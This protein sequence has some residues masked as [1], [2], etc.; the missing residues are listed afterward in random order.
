MAALLLRE[1]VKF[2]I[3]I[4]IQLIQGTSLAWVLEHYLLVYLESTKWIF[5]CSTLTTI[6]SW[7]YLIDKISLCFLGGGFFPILPLL[8]LQWICPFEKLRYHICISVEN[9]SFGF[10]CFNTRSGN[11]FRKM[12]RQFR[13]NHRK[14][15]CISSHICK[16]TGKVVTT[17]QIC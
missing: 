15:V 7:K 8:F 10:F 14:S 5:F 1:V 13:S 12:L 4:W 11:S 6:K 16:K 2:L 9:N 3:L 17:L